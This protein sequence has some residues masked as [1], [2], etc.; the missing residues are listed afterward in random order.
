[1]NIFKESALSFIVHG[2]VRWGSG[3]DLSC[4]VLSEFPRSSAL[5]SFFQL[6]VL[7]FGYYPPVLEFSDLLAITTLLF[8]ITSLW[9]LV[10]KVAIDLLLI[11]PQTR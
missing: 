5:F 7:T 2:G 3:A 4:L 1:M 10:W 8:H 9:I 11:L 6:Y